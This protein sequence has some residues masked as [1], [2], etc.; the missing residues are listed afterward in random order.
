MTKIVCLAGAKESGKTTAANFLHGHL[1]KLN[2]VIREYEMTKAGELRV[3]T[4]YMKDGEVKEDMGVLDLS[5]KDDLYT[6]YADQMIWPYV[7][8]Y[9]FADALKELCVTMFDISHEQAYG[10]YKNSLTKLKWEN[11]PGVVT[12]EV[13]KEFFDKHIDPPSTKEDFLS[14]GLT[15]HK[16]GFMTAREVLQ[17]VGTDI[18][19]RMYEPV[20]VNLLMNKIK[21]DSPL[22]AVIADCRFDNEA[23]AVKE[24]GG[25]LVYLTR[26]PSEDSHSSEDGFS[27]FTDFNKTIDNKKLNIAASNQE[28]LDFLIMSGVSEFVNKAN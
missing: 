15:I 17:F 11:M 23:R 9:N 20:W 4:H 10:T 14:M 16:S 26:R 7:K 28:L 27:T 19:R 8:M 25:I 13:S 18:F 6:Q 21:M 5:R 2:E 22:V 3:N 12:P 1:L 24:E